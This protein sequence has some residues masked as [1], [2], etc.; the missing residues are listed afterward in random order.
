MDRNSGRTN[1]LRSHDISFAH[2]RPFSLISLSLSLSSVSLYLLCVH[3][4]VCGCV[5]ASPVGFFS[6]CEGYKEMIDS[7]H[8]DLAKITGFAACSAQPNSGAQGE[9]AGLLCIRSYHQSRGDHH[10]NVCIIPVSAH[11]TNPASAVLA[12]MK[13][14]VVKSDAK[15]NVDID[16]L[17]EKVG[18]GREGGREAS[19]EELVLVVVFIINP[20]TCLFERASNRIH[21]GESGLGV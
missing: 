10:R 14:V 18:E 21:T 15:G 6:Q 2:P 7:L 3:L 9:Y 17:R 19:R 16:D 5:C 13:V 1:G 11:G 4:C 12:G 8:S 20:E